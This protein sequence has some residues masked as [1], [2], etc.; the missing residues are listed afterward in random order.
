MENKDLI[1]NLVNC[2]GENATIKK[3]YGDPIEANGKTIIPVAQMT[4]GLGGGRVQNKQD[5]AS[6]DIE[7]QSNGEGKE[8]SKKKSSGGG[9]VSIKPKGIYEI[10]DQDSRFI[11]A[12]QNRRLQL[13][14]FIGFAICYL[15]FRRKRKK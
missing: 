13:A 11:P 6:T 14:G 15:F 9:G 2:L 4:F 7:D 3:V 1:D 8:A 5:K 12:N 10:T